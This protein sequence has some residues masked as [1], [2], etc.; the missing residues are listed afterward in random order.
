MQ[1]IVAVLALIA[2][3]MFAARLAYDAPLFDSRLQPAVSVDSV[4]PATAT[5]ALMYAGIRG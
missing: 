1:K 2:L 4:I 5:P 3:A